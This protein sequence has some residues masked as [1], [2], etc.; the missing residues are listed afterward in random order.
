M[1]LQKVGELYRK[2][3]LNVLP[4]WRES[5]RPSTTE[6]ASY[7][8]EMY[9]GVFKTDALC[10][11]CGAISKN[12]EVID[13]D[14]QGYSYE[15]WKEIVLK[16]PGFDDVLSTLVIERS[17]SGGIH[18]GYRSEKIEPTQK[19]CMIQ[20]DGRYVTT[21][22]TRSEGSVILVAPSDG[23]TL[24]QNK[25]EDVPT[26]P[27]EVRDILIESARSLTESVVIPRLSSTNRVLYDS[28]SDEQDVAQFLREDDCS[29]RLLLN[30]G[31]TCVG[32]YQG[33]KELWRRPG[34]KTGVSAT[35]DK[36][37]GLVYCWT[38]NAYPLDQ[39][40]TYTPLQLLATLEFN[41][42]E[43]EAAKDVVQ[44][45][46]SDEQVYQRSFALKSVEE[47]T[48]LTQD[49]YKPTE[50]KYASIYDIKFPEICLNPGGYL[51]DV[52]DYTD[53]ISR[54][55]QRVLA[56][57]AAITTLGHVMSRRIVYKYSP[58][59]PALYTL[60]IS[61]PSSGKS[62]GRVANRNILQTDPDGKSIR[63]L[64][65]Q[66]ESVQA[67]QMA[68]G[69][70]KK[71]MLFQDEFG[72]WLT[73]I[74]NEKNNGNKARII[75]EVL[76][77][78][79]EATNPEY[80]PRVTAT[81]IRQTGKEPE[82]IEYPSFSLYGVTNFAELQTAIGERLL[83]NG[84][85]ARVLFVV[86]NNTSPLDLP[87]FKELQQEADDTVPDKIRGQLIQFLE[88]NKTDPLKNRIPTLFPVDIDEEAYDY[89]RTYA[90]EKDKEY[91]E[92][93]EIE[94]F[95]LKV[96]KGRTYEKTIKYALNFAVS[97]YGAD[98]N[99]LHI[100]LIA[101][102]QAVA[103]SKYEHEI[104][105]F[106]TKTEIS[107]SESENLVKS[108]EK[109]L[110]SIKEDSFTKTAFTRKFQKLNVLER[111]QALK[112]LEE[113]GVLEVGYIQCDSSRKKSV[114]YTIN[115]RYL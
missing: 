108:V 61:P 99:A 110:R 81:E 44:H 94:S 65:E 90:L 10:L 67:L 35:L 16:N 38:S 40:Q 93:D 103:L 55:K 21:I 82:A 96:L 4:A 23:Y 80:R 62:F 84:F 63:E 58:L 78:F 2:A 32:D 89:V 74:R 114:V 71:V 68:L 69:M 113:K 46:V 47:Y 13:F 30:N 39:N 92:L 87:T 54:R 29:R 34:K 64:A 107:G 1:K 72:A 27:R 83:K 45:S 73:S 112:T 52:I 11:V 70:T 97:R 24:I 36:N 8:K 85:I 88:F 105:E 15:A 98:V 86:G 7:Q 77:L 37:T 102:Q 50:L 26:L 12:L 3:G 19:L 100:D 60:G 31:W 57:A 51:Q 79:S 111:N 5:K 115:R 91:L 101:A 49:N 17:Q 25:W 48:A 59:S 42:D 95:D 28:V 109:W 9:E 18:V 75:D 22:E 6:W 14:K 41:G 66:L 33:D 53:H 56:F 76:K 106:L 43:S 20:F 104:Y